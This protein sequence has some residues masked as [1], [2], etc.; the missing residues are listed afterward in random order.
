MLQ[1]I[2]QHDV[3]IYARLHS[4]TV[5]PPLGRTNP[6][7]LIWFRTT[8]GAPIRFRTFLE[9]PLGPKHWSFEPDRIDTEEATTTEAKVECMF[10]FTC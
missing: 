1:C 9:P 3:S 6:G 4:K 2:Q 8:P 5:K 7:A 10:F